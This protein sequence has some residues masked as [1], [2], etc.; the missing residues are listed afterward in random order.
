[1]IGV[2]FLSEASGKSQR[3][4]VRLASCLAGRQALGDQIERNFGERKFLSN[5]KRNIKNNRMEDKDIV[6][7]FLD[8]P[9]WQTFECKRAAIK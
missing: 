8:T 7:I 6:K 3:V 4:L 5:I 9:E 2:Q 1:M